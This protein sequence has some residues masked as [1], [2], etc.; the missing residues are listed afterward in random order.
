MNIGHLRQGSGLSGQAST[1]STSST[2]R[3]MAID[4]RMPRLTTWL[5]ILSAWTSSAMAQLPTTRLLACFPPGGKQGTQVE[6]TIT[7]GTDLEGVSTLYFSHPGITATQKTQPVKGKDQPQPVANQFVVS[8]AGDVPP[9]L[10]DVRA[11]GTYGVSNPRFF[12][13][14]DLAETAESE[15]NDRPE[16]ATAV[17]IES[18]INGRSNR[19]TDVDFY[20]LTASAG[21]RVII[22]CDAERI[23]SRMDATFELFDSSGRRIAAS[24]DFH[25]HDPLIDITFP[26]DGEYLLKVFDFTYGGGNEHFY[27]LT[28]SNKP[29]LDFV[30]PPSITM[31]QP[32]SV[33]VFGRLLPSGGPSDLLSRD[34]RP[35]EQQAVEARFAED[36]ASHQRFDWA[37]RVTAAE[38]G[39]DAISFRLPSPQG[40]SNP[41]HIAGARDPVVVE[42]EPNNLPE[43]SQTVNVPCEVVGQ[44]QTVGDDDWFQFQAEKGEVYWIEV[45][46]SR[47]GLPTDADL[48]VVQ[49]TKN[50]KGQE[51]VKELKSLNAST[52]TIGGT[53]FHTASDDPIFRLQAPAA[54]T[55]RIRIED[56]Y[57]G[58][59]GDP[60]LIYRVSLRHPEPDFRVVAMPA[61]PKNV[62]DGNQLKNADPWTL[63]LRK[64]GS[65]QFRLFAFRRDGFNGP[66]DV[67]VTGLPPGVTCSGATI[68]PGQTET[69]VV[70]SAEEKAADWVGPLSLMAK[71]AIGDV[72]LVRE[73]RPATVVWPARATPAKVRLSRDFVLAVGEVAPY[74]VHAQ[75]GE[76]TVPQSYQLQVPVKLT[77]R[78]E[79]KNPVSLAAAML[80]PKVQNGALTLAPNQAEGVI[81]LFVPQD[82]PPGRYTFYLQSTSKVSFKKPADKKAADRAV[83]DPSNPVTLT[84]TP[85]PLVLTVKPPNKGIIKRGAQIEIPVTLARR[86]GATG[87]VKLDL[88]I[89]PGITGVTAAEVEVP[90]DAKDAKIIIQANAEASEGNH[91]GVVVRARITVGK[92]V[93]EVHQPIPLN[94]QK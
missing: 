24:R 44:F 37:D 48:L 11:V 22:S 87:P 17:S 16:Q 57:R 53:N 35:L 27:R 31:D 34:H 75:W 92:Q 19:A 12:V 85:G 67:T 93:V 68:G 61:M 32:A 55:Y 5:L 76:A 26:A 74:A 33:A 79:F 71:A 90:A 20:R 83:F 58:S 42:T 10:Y 9:G 6:F 40:V 21:Q 88:R 2:G 47:L 63:R 72:E 14:G 51:Q 28:V 3:H 4:C 60:S 29:H 86:G 89:P 39:L 59:R 78:G 30:F 7:S 13:V 81:R 25:R 18:T 62:N 49:V 38:S 46:S 1:V 56:L 65:E 43:Q 69:R 70:L 54:G 82:A 15:P 66:I 77:R 50:D 23:D 94:V 73:V 64:G 41:I 84:I 91:A 45:I 36:P 8:I 52:A 80:P